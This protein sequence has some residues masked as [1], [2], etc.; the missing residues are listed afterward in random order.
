MDYRKYNVMLPEGMVH[1]VLEE[2]N[3]AGAEGKIEDHLSVHLCLI[4]DHTFAQCCC[5]L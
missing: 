3:Y 5:P 1:G 2:V 4:I